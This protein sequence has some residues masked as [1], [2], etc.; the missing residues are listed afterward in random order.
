MAGGT[1][2]T[3]IQYDSAGNLTKVT[4][5]DTTYNA[6]T[7]DNAHRPTKLT[8]KLS[9]TQN[10]TYNSAG[11]LTQTLWKSAGGTTTF[12]QTGTF[13]ALG[14]TLTDI[15]GVSQATAYTY[16][17]QGN[18][19]TITDPLSHVT[20]QTFDALNRLKTVTD[21]ATDLTTLTYDAHDRP[22]TVTDP[23][24]KVTSYVYDGFGDVIQQT[25][26]DSGT[27]VFYYDP[28]ANVT[29]KKD[30]SINYTSAT[31]DA[32]DRPLTRTYPADSSLN[33]SYTYDQTGHGKGIGRLTSVTD[34]AGSLSLSYDERGS[35]TS[36]ARTIGATTY[37][38]TYIWDSVGRL[39]TVTYPTGGWKVSYTRDNAGQQAIVT[40]TQPGHSAVNLATSVNHY[41]FGP[42]KTFT[43]GNGV[44]D[45]RTYDL[46]YRMTNVTDTG[47]SAVSNLTYGY[48]ADDNVT[49][50]TDAVTAANNQTVHYDVLDRISYASSG[51]YG[52]IGSITYDSS[53]NRKTYGST[54]FTYSTTSNRLTV[55][56]SSSVGST[57]T[58]NI[59]TYGGSNTASY[60]KANQ[61]S[62]LVLGANTSVYAYDAFGQRMQTTV[63]AGTPSVYQ[64]DQAGNML[65]ET[66]GGTETDYAYLDGVPLY[67]I[68][69]AAA[70]L[71]ALHTDKI[72]TVVKGTNASKTVVF[73]AA[74][75]PNGKTTPVSSITQNIR[76]PGMYAANSFLNHNGFRNYLYGIGREAE[77]DPLGLAGGLNPYIYGLNNP[78]KNIDPLGLDVTVILYNG[79]V[80]GRVQFGHIGIGIAPPGQT[81]APGQTVGF[82]PSPGYSPLAGLFGTPSIIQQDLG[83]TPMSGVA[84]TITIPTT[85]QQDAQI[86][87][88]LNSLGAGNSANYSLI[89]TGPGKVENCTVAA[90]RALNAGGIS[91]PHTI[92]PAALMQSLQTTYGRH[93]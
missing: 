33:V 19:L 28:D 25:S 20:T 70:T 31:Y 69:P 15:N 16:D 65:T 48:D 7:Y 66:N 63:N 4:L 68:Q 41:P 74:Y 77:V 1:R 58:G 11:N 6:F 57:A 79:A 34:Q 49:G 18:A 47:T 82:Y 37:T 67:A 61:M 10:I 54:N 38:T 36:N 40:A 35:V 8:N 84:N 89:A 42:V 72:G 59:T 2:T 81:V 5:P 53:S 64:F 80:V 17:S 60:N 12:K 23:R 87:N 90:A 85:A 92:F 50:I 78:Y 44:T 71:S 93:N 52:T 30:G 62:Q 39:A 3:S 91:T 51:I 43:Y 32:L 73:S 26:P 55:A 56:G 29:T 45:S 22:L 14:R 88:F 24:G 27:T 83:A 9:E 76:F 75:D 21:A 13:D 46:A 86:T